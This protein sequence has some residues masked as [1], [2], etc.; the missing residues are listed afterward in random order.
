MRVRAARHGADRGHERLRQAAAD[1]DA[2]LHEVLVQRAARHGQ[3][4]LGAHL[5]VV[6]VELEAAHRQA[7]VDARE[8]LGDMAAPAL[9]HDAREHRVEEQ[10]AGLLH[11]LHA[12][13][14][15]AVRPAQ[16]AHEH[17][18]VRGLGEAPLAAREQ[19]AD[20]VLEGRQSRPA[21][22]RSG[23]HPSCVPPWV[24]FDAR[25]RRRVTPLTRSYIRPRGGC[26]PL[27]ARALAAQRREVDRVSGGARRWPP[28]TA[29]DE[30]V[31][32]GQPTPSDCRRAEQV[33]HELVG[34]EVRAGRI[35]PRV[36]AAAGR[37]ASP[38]S[39]QDAAVHD[40]GEALGAPR[41]PGR[42]RSTPRRT[43]R[44]P[45]ARRCAPCASRPAVTIWS[46]TTSRLVVVDGRGSSRRCRG[47]RAPS[48]RGKAKRP[49]SVSPSASKTTSS[50]PSAATAEVAVDGPR[51]IQ[52][53]RS[54]SRLHAR[55]ARLEVLAPPAARNSAPRGALAA[56]AER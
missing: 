35:A 12:Q 18:R 48:W 14:P 7:V 17:G 53:S 39:A 41:P 50:S 1:A 4:D 29:R 23:R 54:A 22:R 28:S 49:S 19:R 38:S 40:L 16:L 25:Y 10:D 15:A 5:A 34:L 43:R 36:A 44:P 11:H 24:G 2:A 3:R 27:R 8:Q 21:L 13:Q 33:E 37:A 56:P 42:G 45:A 47:G 26:Q 32:R 31:R 9:G 30:L 46:A 51:T 52:P 20:L 6:V 55:A